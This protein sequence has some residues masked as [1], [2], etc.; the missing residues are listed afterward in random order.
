MLVDRFIMGQLLQ[1]DDAPQRNRRGIEV[2]VDYQY[3]HD[4]VLERNQHRNEQ[5]IGKDNQRI[6]GIGNDPLEDGIFQKSDTACASPAPMM[7]SASVEWR[8]RAR[9]G[10]I[11]PVSKSKWLHWRTEAAGS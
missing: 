4:I 5:D 1:E 8:V 6:G 10:S 2:T 9:G 7:M 11:R 3:K